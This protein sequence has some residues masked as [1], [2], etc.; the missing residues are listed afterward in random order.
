MLMQ[1][2]VVRDT[3]YVEEDRMI[4]ATMHAEGK[5]VS[6]DASADKMLTILRADTFTSGAHID[7]YD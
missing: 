1:Q 6:P 4:Y 2:K 5:L 3:L 7:Y